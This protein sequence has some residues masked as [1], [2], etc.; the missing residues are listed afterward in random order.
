MKYA[1]THIPSFVGLYSVLFTVASNIAM[2]AAQFSA[3][4]KVSGSLAVYDC[5]NMES[6]WNEVAEPKNACTANAE[7]SFCS[8]TKST[9]VQT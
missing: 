1:V 3:Q 9:K 5:V 8:L 4:N 2:K 6:T 7:F